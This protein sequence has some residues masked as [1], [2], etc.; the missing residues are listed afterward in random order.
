MALTYSTKEEAGKPAL[1]FS[2]KGTDGK[3][4]S[5]TDFQKA[6]VLGIFFICNHCPYVVAVQDRINDL[7]KEFGSKGV[8]IIG[9]NSNDAGRY[10]DDNF[11]AMKRR[12]REVGYVFPYLWDETQEV[13]RA[14]GAVCT[15]DPF[16]YERVGSEFLLRYHGRIDD[17][18]Q[19]EKAVRRRDLAEAV[20][21]ILQGKLVSK[22][23]NPSMGCSIKWKE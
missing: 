20:N 23:Q 12:T 18:W 21:A 19:D 2:L 11:D 15:P 10:P 9:I 5:L 4:W 3:T 13:A 6:K 14:Y 1:D 16:V 8:Q 22:D 17:N 7:A